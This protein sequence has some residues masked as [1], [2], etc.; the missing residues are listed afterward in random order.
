[1][2]L[3]E[4][5]YALNF[6]THNIWAHRRTGTCTAIIHRALHGWNK[7]IAFLSD[8]PSRSRPAPRPHH[9]SPNVILARPSGQYTW[10]PHGPCMEPFWRHAMQALIGSIRGDHALHASVDHGRLVGHKL[11]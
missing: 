11:V 5:A 6:D 3:P 9:I 10:L 2:L 4:L 8:A 1:M 7:K